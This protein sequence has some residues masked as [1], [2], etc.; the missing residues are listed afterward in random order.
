MFGNFKIS[1]PSLALITAR[2]RGEKFSERGAGEYNNSKGWGR[3]GAG[4]M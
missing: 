1:L 4:Y 2:G 3:G